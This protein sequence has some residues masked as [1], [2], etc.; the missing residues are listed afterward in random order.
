[1]PLAS[2][3]TQSTFLCDASG[4][5]VN[6]KMDCATEN[7]SHMVILPCMSSISFAFVKISGSQTFL[8]Y[9]PL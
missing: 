3:E 8:G 4:I 9:D 6:T 2:S 1:M 5:S 7:E